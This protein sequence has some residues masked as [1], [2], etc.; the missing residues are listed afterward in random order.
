MCLTT[1]D[2]R[3]NKES[4]IINESFIIEEDA[5]SPVFGKELLPRMKP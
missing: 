5:Y 1:K 3:H 2:I 4:K